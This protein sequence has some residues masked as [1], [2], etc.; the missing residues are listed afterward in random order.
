[1]E[2]VYR[3][4][5]QCIKERDYESI[6]WILNYTDPK[7]LYDLIS[8]MNPTS[9][10]SVDGNYIIILL[11]R[12]GTATLSWSL[13]HGYILIRVRFL[14]VEQIDYKS[15]MKSIYSKFHFITLSI[16]TEEK[17]IF[18]IDRCCTFEDCIY[19]V[20]LEEMRDEINDATFDD[21]DE[22][23]RWDYVGGYSDHER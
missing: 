6:G 23:G 19:S 14:G 16:E 3:N 20:S 2:K 12:K 21:G 1:M 13:K 17:D 8:K 4:F 18:S 11:G 5:I 7:A 9:I 10:S 15:L 22:I